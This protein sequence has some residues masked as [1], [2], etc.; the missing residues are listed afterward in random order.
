MV[1]CYLFF[2]VL[3][4]G[5][6]ASAQPAPPRLIVRGDDMGFSHAGNEALILAHN[7]GIETSI[8]L[9]VASPWFPEA[10][11][12]L[13]KNPNID[14]GIHLA[15][16]SEWEN[17]KWRP[18]TDCSS[19]KDSSGYFYPMVFPNKNYPGRSIS[20]NHWKLEDIEKEFRAQVELAL[21]YIPRIS[22]VSAHMGCTELSKEVRALT[23]KLSKEY[24][25]YIDLKSLNVQSVSYNGPHGTANEK[26]QSFLAMLET[27]L[28]A[29][30][31]CSLTIPHW[32]DLK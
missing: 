16:T 24:N 26:L 6:M 5:M 31:T 30:P 15:I 8:E 2:L 21:R 11:K 20:E 27:L 7:E 25:I 28:R 1:K 17:V 9:I 4:S 13:E 18:L 10:V 19:L 29:R 23:E 3:L 14:V 12:L 22:H 32:T